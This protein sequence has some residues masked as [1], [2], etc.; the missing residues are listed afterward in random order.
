MND[1]EKLTFFDRLNPDQTLQHLIIKWS[2]KYS[3]DELKG[4]MDR[5]FQL[6]TRNQWKRERYAPGF[7]ID[8]YSLDPKSWLRFPILSKGIK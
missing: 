3:K 1:I 7:H 8:E 5:F 2:N 4:F 6:W